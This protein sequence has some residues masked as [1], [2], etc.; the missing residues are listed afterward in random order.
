[1]DRQVG[2]ISDSDKLVAAP[3]SYAASAASQQAVSW[4]CRAKSEQVEKV[5]K[6]IIDQLASMGHN[7]KQKK[8]VK[9]VAKQRTSSST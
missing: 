7:A 8:S 1:M 2:T 9:K 4:T 5:L 3:C 6:L